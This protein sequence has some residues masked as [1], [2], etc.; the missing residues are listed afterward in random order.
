M[1]RPHMRTWWLGALCLGL[2]LLFFTACNTYLSNDDPDQQ[3]A[4]DDAPDDDTSGE[5]PPCQS[6]ALLSFDL[7][8][9][10]RNIPFPSLVFTKPSSDKATGLRVD[11]SGQVTTFLDPIFQKTGDYLTQLGEMSG[12]GVTMPVWF[13]AAT[14]PNPAMLPGHDDPNET[15][16]VV[17]AVVEGS[18]HPHYGEFW[19]LNVRYLPET[20]VIELVPH[21]PFAEDTTYVCAIQ[22][23]LCTEQ[24]DCYETPAHLAYVM[25]PTADPANADHELLE[26]YRDNLQLYFQQFF[27]LYGIDRRGV[28]SATVFHTQAVTQELSAIRQRLE[29]RAV[30]DPPLMYGDW[31]KVE[32]ENPNIDSVWEN[33]YFTIDWRENGVFSTD[34]RGAPVPAAQTPVTLRLTIPSRASGYRPPY[35][36]VMFGHG[37]LGDR[38]Q[39]TPIYETLAANGIA[40][41]AIDWTFHGDRG[42]VLG[43]LPDYLMLIGRFLAF[44]PILSPEEM[45]DNYR[46]GVADMIWLKHAIRQLDRLDLAPAAKGGD[47]VPDLDTETIMFAGISM[48]SAHGTI[49]A[50]IEPDINTFVFMSGAANWRA[51]ILE[52][53]LDGVMVWVVGSVLLFFQDFF[54]FDENEHVALFYQ[55]QLALGEAGDPYSYATQVIKQ[56]LFEREGPLNLLHI[57]P[58]YDNVTGALGEAELARSLGTTLLRPLVERIDEV[59]VADTPFC[60]PATFQYPTDNH[61]F[62]REP[63]ADYFKVGHRQMAAFFRTALDNGVATI[64]NPYDQ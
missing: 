8:P 62:M 34:S 46:Q 60:G 48:G 23:D 2:S 41:A 22:S 47:G 57:M 14:P 32:N 44:T 55:M 53:N 26:P 56:P 5:A 64:I 24:C 50:A 52:G 4:D 49:L 25:S 28:I 27:D 7:T 58:A 20:Q 18:N 9:G 35:P 43:A 45:R 10:A 19:P 1:L 12:F 36:V 59:E 61:V 38:I 21:L 51:S 29:E 6:G 3:P 17:C 16:S 11:I 39:S 15:D 63:E 37:L 40:T 31:T 33:K 54:G 30:L 42:Q 13:H